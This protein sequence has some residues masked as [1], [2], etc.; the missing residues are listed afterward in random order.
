MISFRYHIVSIAA[1]L[2][3]LAAGVALGGGPLSELGR[4]SDAAGE[5]AEGRA[6]E[7][8]RELEST[9]ETAAFQDAFASATASRALSGELEGREVAVVALPS[10]DEEVT[11]SLTRLVQQAGGSVS[12]SYQAQPGLVAADGKSLVDTLGAQILE[13]VDGTDVPAEASTYDRMGQ[14]I[15]RAVAAGGEGGARV[16]GAADDILSSLRGAELLTGSSDTGNRG[17]LVLLVLGSQPPEG[18]G[19]QNIVGGLATGLGT[20]ADGMVVAGTTGSATNGILG[21]LRDEVSFTSN[22]S[23]VDSVQTV[24]GR[25]ATVLGLAEDLRNEPGHYGAVGIDGALPRG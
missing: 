1:V 10:A 23:S 7:L 3:A 19:V 21:L 11:T 12:G 25:V 6:E 9:E 24:S 4:P 13:S 16:D 20:Q 14:L 8:A 15:G 17:S 18:E 2:L 22:V 5:R